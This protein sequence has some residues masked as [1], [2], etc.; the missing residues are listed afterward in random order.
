MVKNGKRIPTE[1]DLYKYAQ[2]QLE[3]WEQRR[4]RKNAMTR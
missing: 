1:E 4:S 2:G 3:Q